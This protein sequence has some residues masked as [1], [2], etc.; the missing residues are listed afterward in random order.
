[1][2]QNK[3]TIAVD[4][5][6]SCG[7]STLSKALAKK[8][9]YLF[10]DSGAMYRGV[11]L[12]CMQNGFIN[13]GEPDQELIIAALPKV[14]LSFYKNEQ[15]DKVELILNGQNVENK[16][17]NKLKHPKRNCIMRFIRSTNQS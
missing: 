7:K 12:Y 3:I 1:M 2:N 14:S 11:T 15:T 4:G 16:I 17:R 10:I 5:Y 13:G 9:G 6:S 8:L